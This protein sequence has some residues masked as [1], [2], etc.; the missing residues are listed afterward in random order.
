[1]SQRLVALMFSPMLVLALGRGIAVGAVS[2]VEGSAVRQAGP[3][4]VEQHATAVSAE[5]PLPRQLRTV[6]PVFP[7]DPDARALHAALMIRTT[8]DQTGAVVEARPLRFDLRPPARV[9]V[10]PDGIPSRL[11]E[12]VTVEGDDLLAKLDASLERARIRLSPGAQPLDAAR[13]K[14][15]G[16]A[17]IDA[18][19]AAVEQWQYGAPANGPLKFD[20]YVMFQNGIASAM[21]LIGRQTMPPEP[22][23]SFT[24]SPLAEGAVRVGGN[25]RPPA[26]VQDAPPVYPPEAREA[27]VQGVVIL[28]IRIEA[29]G[30]VSKAR[31]LR[32]IPLLDQ[33]AI[34]AVSQWL[35][36]P[37]L[38]NGVATPVV[39]T[40]TVQF[41]LQ[42]GR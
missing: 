26:K 3:G 36:E 5:N 1:M 7:T 9:V 19:V 6:M 25:I 8:V 32:S 15:I 22:P 12:G 29:N 21:P 2:R 28:E 39:L 24:E 35:F 34:A 33:A 23:P 40:V 14:T 31:V 13:L 30:R 42:D 16:H 37:T 41:M 17:F 20:V 27:R 10:R 4:P 18:A 11:H 38:V